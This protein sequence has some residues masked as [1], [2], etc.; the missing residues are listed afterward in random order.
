M[1]AVYSLRVGGRFVPLES[2]RFVIGRA[3]DCDVRLLDGGASRRHAALTAN[4]PVLLLEDLESRN[5]VLVNGVRLHGPRELQLGDRIRIG[6]RELVVIDASLTARPGT[7][8][9]PPLEG[10]EQLP[11]HE[12]DVYEVLFEACRVAL[13]DEDVSGATYA[14]TNLFLGMEEGLTGGYPPV[15]SAVD[16]LVRYV[17]ALAKLSGRRRP[18]ERLLS[19]FAELGR[20]VSDDDLL[21]LQAVERRPSQEALTGYVSKLQSRRAGLSNDEYRRLRALTTPA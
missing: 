19:L 7:L 11:T 4:G 18:L 8:A 1:N 2:G 16:Q 20:V 9:P 3:A 15:P 13:A 17:F 6:E 12:H 14:T 21:R 5:G 10:R